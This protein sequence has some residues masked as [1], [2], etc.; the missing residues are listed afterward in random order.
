MLKLAIDCGYP[1]IRLMLSQLSW[2]EHREL[3][4]LLSI[5]PVGSERLD[6]HF[7]RLMQLVNSIPR[8]FFGGDDD[9]EPLTLAD[10]Q[11]ESMIYEAPELEADE[12]AEGAFLDATLM[13]FM[14]GRGLVI[15]DEAEE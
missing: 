3:K 8:A 5:E 7:A 13:G 4:D 11:L 9:E 6:W 12:D 15:V 1:S 2:R 14:S 10:W